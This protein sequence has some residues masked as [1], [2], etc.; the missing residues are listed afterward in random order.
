MTYQQAHGLGITMCNTG[1]PPFPV[2]QHSQSTPVLK[3][4]G[5]ISVLRKQNKK[6]QTSDETDEMELNNNS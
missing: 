4:K 2:P 5:L 6:Q 1:L 3:Y